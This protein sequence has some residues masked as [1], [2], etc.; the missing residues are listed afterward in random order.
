MNGIFR[1]PT[2]PGATLNRGVRPAEE[3]ARNFAGYLEPPTNTPDAPVTRADAWPPLNRGERP[4]ASHL[5][6]FQVRLEPP[7]NRGER[8]AQ[9][10]VEATSTLLEPPLNPPVRVFS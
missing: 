8:P 7:L 2:E 6:P 4:T 1:P 9:N 10:N 3:V 5:K